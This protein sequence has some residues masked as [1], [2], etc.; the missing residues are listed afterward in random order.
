MQRRASDALYRKAEDELGVRGLAD[1]VILVGR[2]QFTCVV[3]NSFEIPAPSD[4][5]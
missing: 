5:E 3:L 1:L 2:Y 4:T